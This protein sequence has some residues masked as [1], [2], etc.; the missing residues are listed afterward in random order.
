[1]RQFMV[2]KTHPT[3]LCEKGKCSWISNGYKIT[4]DPPFKKG[5]QKTSSFRVTFIVKHTI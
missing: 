3:F 1:M 5:G 4:P 2:R